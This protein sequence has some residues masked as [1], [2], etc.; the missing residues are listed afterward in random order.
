[1]AYATLND[2]IQRFGR[3]EIAATTTDLDCPRGTVDEARVKQVL[4]DAS[5]V[6]DSYLQ[7]RYKL[8]VSPVT[9][10]LVR[11]CCQL[12]R[13]DLAMGGDNVP[14]EQIKSGQQAAM[15]WLCDVAAGKAT[16][17]AQAV[18]ETGSIWSRV[19]TRQTE[20]NAVAL[21]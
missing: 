17:D 13:F 8:P 18:N 19:S 20:V 3:H 15:A 6:M 2:L 7:R 5:A 1:M 16:L 21:W 12:A 9:P 14:S 10:V 11:V 4:D